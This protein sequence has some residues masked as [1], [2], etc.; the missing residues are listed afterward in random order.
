VLQ[1]VRGSV[2]KALFM[3]CYL[4]IIIYLNGAFEV[5]EL[6]SNSEFSNLVKITWIQSYLAQCNVESVFFGGGLG[7]KLQ[8]LL[9]GIT[10]IQTEVTLLESVRMF[11][12]FF[13]VILFG[14][15]LMPSINLA[16][17]RKKS[18]SVVVFFIYLMFSLTN[19]VLFNGIG[20]L[21]AIWYW[22]EICDKP[23]VR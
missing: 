17:Y 22:V 19:P 13:A 23:A 6:L 12:I 7:V 14:A 15:V 2:S 3:L 10:A 16:D 11:G 4:L 18:F 9:F 1:A 8:N 21:V 5:A 20:A